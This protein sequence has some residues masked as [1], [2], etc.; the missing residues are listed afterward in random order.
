MQRNPPTHT[1]HH[2]NSKMLAK[3]DDIRP[4]MLEIAFHQLNHIEA[5]LKMKLIL[6]LLLGNEELHELLYSSL[7]S[8]AVEA[9]ESHCKIEEVSSYCSRTFNG[10][11]PTM[12]K[13][14]KEYHLQSFSKYKTLFKNCTRKHRNLDKGAKLRL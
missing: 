1:H 4:A 12:K 8:A 13:M 5:G 14:K 9:A 3:E 10:L 7:E 11:E 6:R 2:R